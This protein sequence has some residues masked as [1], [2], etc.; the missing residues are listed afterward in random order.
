LR[1]DSNRLAKINL[2][3]HLSQYK[4]ETTEYCHWHIPEAH[5]LESWSDTR[6]YDGTVSVVQPLIEPLYEGKT[7][8][9]VMAVFSEQYDRRPYDIVRSYWQ[10]ARQSGGASRPE[11]G[12]QQAVTTGA[13]QVAGAPRSQPVG[14]Q[15]AQETT[16]VADF[17]AW[18]RKTLHD[19][20]APNTA[21]PAKT[22]SLRSD[23]ASQLFQLVIK[24]TATSNFDLVFRTDPTIYDGRFANNGWLQELPKP[25]TKLTWDNA[26]LMSPKTASE[27]GLENTIGR[28]GG[29]I[30]VSNIRIQ[31]RGREITCPV[32]IMP[33][34]PDNTVTVHLGYG[35][36]RAGYLGT[37][38]GFNAYNIR[39]ADAPW[40]AG[41]VKVDK[42][43]GLSVLAA[44]QIHFTME[45]RDIVRATTYDHY[46]K[47]EAPHGKAH[48]PKPDET[49]YGN[50]HKYEGYAWGMAIDTNS[51]I[52]CNAC[53]VACQAE[54]NIPVVG[55][56]QVERSREMQW[57]RVDTYF[58]GNDVNHPEA[59]NFMPVPCMHCEN[60]PC[61]PVC[62]V[63][64]TAHS[65]EGLNEM[66][67]NRCVGTRY[68]SNNCP[69]KVRRFNF[70]LYQDW[71]EP[72]YQ[73]MRNP[74]VSVR[75]R[76]VMEKCT[77]CVQRIQAA[78]ISAEL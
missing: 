50:P 69:Y 36:T 51:C 38:H 9:E 48:D 41:D 62:P 54:N 58:Q 21:L 60:A 37:G 42:A 68:C 30:N 4:D 40:F 23:W 26:A 22:V 33:G 52:G 1:L 73:L 32:W 10:A 35:R 29:D 57:L 14:G 63:H 65:S 12:K 56:E 18:W 76:G 28:K 25:L 47:G 24:E 78:K 27:L 43:N 39:T 15:P 17:E 64:A 34:H 7:A 3:V 11:A 16:A 75:S 2:R 46:L 20:F 49:L 19:G 74:E 45:G 6:S 55:K 67:Y 31:N 61:E 53:I 77:Y 66:T 13:G 72:T 59:T 5:F 71:E 70:L 44:T 8:H